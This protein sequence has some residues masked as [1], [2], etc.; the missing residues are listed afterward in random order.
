MPSVSEVTDQQRRRIRT[1]RK[2]SPLILSLLTY[3]VESNPPTR[4]RLTRRIR[5]TKE[6]PGVA[7]DE[8]RVAAMTPLPQVLTSFLKKKKGTSSRSNVSTAG[9]KAIT[10]PSVPRNRIQK[11]SVVLGD[12]HAGDCS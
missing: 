7:E 2:T 3:L 8:D 5:T 9:G 4:A 12:L 11:T 10:S 6:V 1:P